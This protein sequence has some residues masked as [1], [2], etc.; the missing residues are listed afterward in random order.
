MLTSELLAE[1]EGLRLQLV[2]MGR[3]IDALHAWESSELQKLEAAKCT[4]PDLNG[5]ACTVTAPVVPGLGACALPEF[6]SS[7][8]HVT[9]FNRALDVRTDD[10]FFS[11]E[12]G[13]LDA[14]D[15]IPRGG[16]DSLLINGRCCS[17]SNVC[18]V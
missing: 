11:R 7:P 2:D 1:Y 14:P 5:V 3:R 4:P 13:F 9:G 8:I 6:V 15:Y 16:V 17:F 12:C 10:D 18:R